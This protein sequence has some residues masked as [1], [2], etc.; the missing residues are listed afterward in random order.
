M[1]CGS[2][3]RTPSSATVAMQPLPVLD[4]PRQALVRLNDR[5]RQ[6]GPYIHTINDE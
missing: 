1:P 6:G 3:L 5:T 2:G 4:A